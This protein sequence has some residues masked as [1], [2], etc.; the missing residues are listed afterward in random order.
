[1]FS[2][3]PGELSKMT[4]VLETSTNPIN[5]LSTTPQQQQQQQQ[6]QLHSVHTLDVPPLKKKSTKIKQKPTHKIA[7]KLLQ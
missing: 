1:M 5:T 4:S 2:V 6:Q 3:K 7:L